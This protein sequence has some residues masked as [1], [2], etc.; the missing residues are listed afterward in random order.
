MIPISD[1]RFRTAGGAVVTVAADHEEGL[2]KYRF[3]ARCGG[4][5]ESEYQDGSDY[6]FALRW[7]KKWADKHAMGCRALPQEA[8]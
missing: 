3:V 5:G 8:G 1:I 7:P 6:E 2:F 4:C